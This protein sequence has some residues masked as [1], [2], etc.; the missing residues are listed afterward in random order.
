MKRYFYFIFAV[1]VALAPQS[2]KDETSEWLDRTPIFRVLGPDGTEEGEVI[3]LNG[4][5][6]T[7]DFT[8]LST[9]AWS[10]QTAG[11]DEY[12]LNTRVGGSGKTTVSLN[13]PENESGAVR[14]ATVSFYMGEELKNEFRIEQAVQEPY[15]DVDPDNVPV[16]GWGGEFTVNVSTN[17]DEWEYSVET[18]NSEWLTETART[19]TSVTFSVPENG[20]GSARRAE[21]LFSVP[22]KP[23]L[24]AYLTVSQS[25]PADPPA[26]LILDVKFNENG[27]AEDLSA[28]G[29]TVDAS[30]RDADCG[31][32]YIE[33]FGRYAATFNNGTIARSSLETGY[34]RVPYD[35]DS[36]FGKKIADGCSYELVF[37]TYYDPLTYTDGLKQVKPFASTQAG[38]LGVC[39]QANTGLIQLE[40][41]AGGKWN[42]PKSTVVPAANQ[43]YHVIGT[44]NKEMETV[45]IYVNGKMEAT[46]NASG[47]FKFQET[48]KDARWFGIGADPN[49]ND[50]G[51]ASFYGEVVVARL[52]DAPMSDDQAMACYKELME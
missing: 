48:N 44:F 8:V 31:V 50:Q 21:L 36:E 20:T 5:S 17:Q 16:L 7:V 40:V 42:S 35:A 38:G 15:L 13:V 47:D 39:L 33:R 10:A 6:Q 24:F 2:C 37:C 18:E 29:M 28:M 51:E 19:A 30:R 45:T 27:S 11:C 25:A 1:L 23:E 41:H 32:R 3:S 49:A 34:Y 43:Y 12:S 22:G 52:Y 26:D 14:N 4:R 46:L 9:E